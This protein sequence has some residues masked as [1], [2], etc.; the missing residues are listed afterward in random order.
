MRFNANRLAKLAGIS[1]SSDRRSLNESGNQS[2]HDEGHDEGVDWYSGDLN[3]LDEPPEGGD[4]DNNPFAMGELDDPPGGG[5]E[6][7]MSDEDAEALDS[8]APVEEQDYDAITDEELGGPMEEMVEINESMLRR[9][10][11]RMKK[12]RAKRNNLSSKRLQE[13]N[14]LRDAIRKEIGSIVE[15]MGD[16]GLYTT[17]NW[18]YG[19]N[20]PQH[21]KPGQVAVAGLGIG[22]K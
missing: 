2:R 10:I 13:E 12:E 22:F 7:T 20:K 9:E 15:E 6:M 1:T 11:S 14:Q 8:L 19:D 16:G 21:S 4:E 17:R 5:D 18:M 3:E